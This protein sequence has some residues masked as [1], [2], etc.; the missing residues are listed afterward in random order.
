MKQKKRNVFKTD[1]WQVTKKIAD[2]K[3]ILKNVSY[4]VFITIYET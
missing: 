3:I 2:I 4:M 1:V